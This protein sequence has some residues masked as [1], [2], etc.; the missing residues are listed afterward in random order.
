MNLLSFPTHSSILAWK[1]AWMEEPGR[2]QSMGLQSQTRLSDFTFFSLSFPT[3]V[4]FYQQSQ[5]LFGLL[6]LS[7]WL[8]L[9]FKKFCWIIVDLQCCVSFG[10]IAKWISYSYTYT[11]SL[12]RLFSQVGHYRVLSSLCYIAGSCQ[13]SV[14]YVVVCICQT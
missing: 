2:L 4:E 11:H 7:L 8:F 6:M 10:C 3:N 9:F 13:L 14:L 12:L 5:F 1:T